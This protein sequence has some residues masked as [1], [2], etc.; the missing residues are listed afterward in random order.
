MHYS[1]PQISIKKFMRPATRQS[2]LATAKYLL[3]AYIYLASSTALACDPCALYNA[4]RLHD[5]EDGAISIAAFQ[6]Y[7]D[8]NTAKNLPKNSIR[9][10]EL[11]KSFST[12]QLL[13]AYEATQD[14]GLQLNLPLVYRRFSELEKFK[15]SSESE[16]GIGDAT[17]GSN[18]TLYR[19]NNPDWSI[20]SAASAA[21]KLPTGDTGSIKSSTTTVAEIQSGATATKH[22]AITGASGGRVLTLGSGSVDYILGTNA[23]ARYKKLLL[24][25]YAQYAIRTEG[26][27][28]YEF[29]D[30][31]LWAVAPGYFI[32]LGHDHSVAAKLALSG[33]SKNKD[34]LDGHKVIGSDFSNLYLGPEIQV[35][36]GNIATELGVDFRVSSEDRDATVVP[37]LKVRAGF[38]YRF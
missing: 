17:I 18:Y 20:Y 32:N 27:F 1:S 34:R 15:A 36:F 31:F 8:Y 28:N 21:V 38:S 5:S 7:T 30:D 12:T 13:V 25:G 23:V 3:C 16:F 26:D 33:E 10:G 29:A 37:E 19:E 11:V 2:I 35:T 4:S 6:Q 22:H 14:L 9:D 24:S